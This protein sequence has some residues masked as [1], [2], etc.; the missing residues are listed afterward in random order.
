MLSKKM[1]IAKGLGLAA[2][3]FTFFVTTADFGDARGGRGGGGG[4]RGGGFH[5]GGHGGG[6]GGK[7]YRPAGN[8][9]FQNRPAGGGNYH[10]PGGR[11]GTGNRPGNGNRP[12][13]GNGNGNTV[14][15]RNCGNNYYGGWDNRPGWGGYGVGVATGLA[16]GSIAYSLPSGCV[17]RTYTGIAYRYCG[18]TWYQPQ[19]YGSSVNYVVVSA[20]Y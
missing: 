15:K 18:S 19:Y 13:H 12:G 3:A 9:G 8:K 6:R 5:G 11:P 17:T 16:I 1:T 10:R 4:G 7:V 20:P 14:C 2:L